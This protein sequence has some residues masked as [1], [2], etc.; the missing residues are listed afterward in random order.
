MAR[1]REGGIVSKGLALAAMLVLSTP[2]QARPFQFDEVEGVA[3]VE[4]TYGLLARV[5]DRD[6]DLVA[7]V[8]GGDAGTANFDD[9]DLNYD[10]GIAANVMQIEA[11]LAARWR[12]FGV[13]LRGFTFYDFEAKLSDRE[14][15][16]LTSHAERYVGSDTELREYY[17]DAN[18]LLRGMPVRVRVGDQ[19]LNWGESRFLRFGAQVMNPL[20]IPASLRPSSS[21]QDVQ[22]P[23]GMLWVAANPTEVLAVEAYYQYDWDP[24]HTPPIGSFFSDTDPLGSGG[25]GGAMAGGGLFSD[26][27][28][29][30][31][32]AFSLPEGTLGFDSDFMRTPGRGTDDPSGQGQFGIS[33]QTI[34]PRL[35]STKLALH[36]ANYHSRLPIISSRAAD[37]A[38]ASQTSSAA[39]AARADT[40]APVYESEGLSPAEAAAAAAAAAQTLTIGEYASQASFFLE[41]PENVQMLALSFNTAT[42]RTGTLV[43][44]EIAHHFGLPLQILPNDVF[45]AAFSPIEF[46]PTFGQG[47][48]GDFA[49]SQVISGVKELDKTQLELGLR[50]LLGPRLGA[51][52]SILGIDLGWV[53][54]HDMP[55]RDE[56]RLGAPGIVG[57]AD[58]D[59]LPTSDS[60]G[61]RL[62]GALTY[63][64]VLGR[65]TV[66]P[67]VAFVHDVSGISPGP[68]AAF[69]EKR[70][71]FNA[72]VSIDHTNTW[73]VQLDYTTLF[74]AGRFNL[75][76]DRDFVRLQISYFY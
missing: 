24:A 47:L 68:G 54:I 43:S 22:L 13:Y 50:Q 7:I 52:Q 57:E 4:L 34:L 62:V 32:A 6:D 21:A 30:L 64:G 38:A 1:V 55:A 2:T 72:G 37:S 76:N 14:R 44:G 42:L 66:Q 70:K 63:E 40:L 49:P 53:H 9:G 60:W 3:N 67:R 31:D 45:T 20:D 61:Y 8:N 5:E 27:G 18:L 12:V 19:V 51:D 36:F 46:T 69:L 23:E 65:F 35:N 56:L 58:F 29:D 11:E 59:H 48:L 41:Y 16:A 71:V 74:G 33:V 15:T 28:T 73:L 39:V 10:R 25:L 26:L 17:V 75:L